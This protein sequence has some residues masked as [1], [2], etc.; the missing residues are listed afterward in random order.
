MNI[1]RPDD[2]DVIESDTD[3]EAEDGEDE[4]GEDDCDEDESDSLLLDEDE[5][6]PNLVP[7]GH[8]R[9]VLAG[10]IEILEKIGEGGM[11]AVWRGLHLKLERIVAVKILDETLQLRPD[12]RER[13]IREARALAL[14]AHRNVVA[15]HDCDELPDG[16]LYL[17]MELLAG[18]TLRDII[19]RREP[20][21]PLEVIDAGMQVCEAVQ[22]AHDLG[23][24]HRDLTPSNIIRLGDAAK[25]VKVLDWGL[26][27][28]LDLFY[29]RAPQKY[30]APPGA[31]LVTPPGCR[32][33][34]PDYMAPEMLRR[35]EPDSPSFCTDVYALAVVLY[36]LLTGR[37]PFVPGDRKL[38]RPIRDV[39]PRFDYHDLEAALRAALRYRPEER[40]QTMAEFREGLELARECLLAQREH[41]AAAGK[42]P[43]LDPTPARPEQVAAAVVTPVQVSTPSQQ[44]HTD[45]AAT[46]MEVTAHPVDGPGVAAND[47]AT[48]C[49]APPPE[50]A[51][52]VQLQPRSRFT[53][54]L[55]AAVLGLAVGVGGTLGLWPDV[56]A[57]HATERTVLMARLELEL[58]RASAAE[59]RVDRCEAEVL[60]RQT[61]AEVPTT[62]PTPP[63]T[64]PSPLLAPEVPAARVL[65]ATSR[66]ARPDS[67][68][69]RAP[70]PKVPQAMEQLA[71]KVRACARKGGITGGPIKV[72]VRRQGGE[73]DAVKVLKYTKDHP[74]F[75]CIDA[76]IRGADLPAA[77][78]PVETFTFP[79]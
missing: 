60:V 78:R 38:P 79:E 35:E 10:R 37:L 17:C 31:R 24:L 44:E 39:L 67:P 63:P 62:P 47:V 5:G 16:R 75:S 36:E 61:A 2:A 51:R 11:G 55:L 29:V 71:S 57:A 48:P 14:L 30:G 54:T 32:F 64:P 15:I 19:K 46:S 23:I 28:L 70:S 21:D 41:V 72:Q 69:P 13:F 58:A 49:S 52:V 9:R 68:R 7:E 59:R 12:G 4:A 43:A 42:I 18:E 34:T 50:L 76:A 66:S 1:E 45:A 22:A 77:D 8:P 26:C 3:D 73:I 27:K 65:A 25:T 53:R 56:D 33:G 74:S 20:V 40:T 6:A